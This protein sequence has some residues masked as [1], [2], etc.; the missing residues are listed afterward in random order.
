MNQEVYQL[1]SD[2]SLSEDKR[3]TSICVI[4][5]N[6]ENL[7]NLREELFKIL[8]INKINELKFTE[9]KTH[10]PKINTAEQF[11]NIAV[12]FAK[13]K[14]IRID[15]LTYDL[16]DSRHNIQGRDD[17]RNVERM[18]YKLIRNCCERW[19]K[20]KWEFYPDENSAY[21][22]EEIQD[23]LNSTKFPRKEVGLLKLFNEERFKLNFI[24]LE[25]KNSLNEPL[26][27]L[28]DLFAG[29]HWFSILYGLECL[30]FISKENTKNQKFLFE[31]FENITED[32]NK[33]KVNRFLLIKKMDELCKKHKLGVSLKTNKH[34]WTPQPDYPINF[35]LYEPQ[36]EYDK[37]PTRKTGKL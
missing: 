15:I 26:V 23:Y 14:K 1:Y 6:K 35:W 16:Q 10:R 3:Y 17:F 31:E 33:T 7:Q 30:R 21:N 29:F 34:L 8:K 37:A 11:I 22:W 25:Q 2:E 36:G 5:G 28:A 9:V 4:S 24:A 32:Y 13:N 19:S 12:E 27:Q 18:Y 20:L